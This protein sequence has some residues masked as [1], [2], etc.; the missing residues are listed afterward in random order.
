MSGD[1]IGNDF[2]DTINQPLKKGSEGRSMWMKAYDRIKHEN[3]INSKNFR[4]GYAFRTHKTSPEPPESNIFIVPNPS[5]V[6]KS[7]TSSL[8][9][10]KTE[11][12]PETDIV[13]DE[14]MSTCMVAMVIT[15]MIL[16]PLGLIC[17][18]VGIAT[19][20]W[21]DTTNGHFGLFQMC[22]T[23]GSC[24]SVANF[25]SG[26]STNC[27]LFL[28]CHFVIVSIISILCTKHWSKLDETVSV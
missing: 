12:D 27:K 19:P 13:E 22:Y 15:C 2:A 16:I 11:N 21:F 6:P 3:H 10:R 28:C 23:S 8:I 18:V 9:G 20:Y 4:N 14:N 25:L 17:L 26:V 24:E 1:K 5:P 7:D